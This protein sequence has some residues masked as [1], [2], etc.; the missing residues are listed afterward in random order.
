MVSKRTGLSVWVGYTKSR[1]L[2]A[3][4]SHEANPS[5][6][7]RHAPSSRSQFQNWIFSSP[8]YP[9]LESLSCSSVQLRL[10]TN[11]SAGTKSN[12][13]RCNPQPPHTQEPFI[14]GRGH[15]TQK[16]R[17]FRAPAFSQNE[18]S[19][20]SMQPLECVLLHHVANPSAHIAIE[21]G[22]IHA[23]IPLHRHLPS[24]QS[25]VI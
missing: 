5:P 22:N 9:W 8:R 15:F 12:Q 16:N 24:L 3:V 7:S 25:I 4:P 23:A 19:A 17:K 11:S 6:H 14:A 20:T 21:H 1:C 10:H 13:K 18:T 2:L